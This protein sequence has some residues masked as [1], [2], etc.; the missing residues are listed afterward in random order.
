MRD[1]SERVYFCSQSGNLRASAAPTAVHV[2]DQDSLE[3]AVEVGLMQE[4]EDKGHAEWMF[5]VRG[6][7]S[8]VVDSMSSLDLFLR[9]L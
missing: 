9:R 7:E 5:V 2:Y 6:D 3:D 1:V 8:E 4:G